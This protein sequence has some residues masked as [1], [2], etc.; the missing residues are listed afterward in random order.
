MSMNIGADIASYVKQIEQEASKV[1]R[2][3]NIMAALVRS[4]NDLSGTALRARS[5]Y[6]TASFNQISD[7][8]DLT[9]QTFTPSVQN[10][11]TPYEFGAQ[12]FITDT[13]LRNDPFNMAS[14]AR[15]ELGMAF[16]QKVEL[17]LLATFSSFTGGT[18]TSA[19]N[20]TWGMLLAA[21]SRLR[22]VA[23]RSDA[24]AVLSP[25]QWHSLGTAIAP[26]AGV[27]Q[28]N[29]PALQDALL[30]NYWVGN[31]G[32]LQIYVTSNLSAGTVT[33]GVFVPDAAALDVRVPFTIEPERDASRRGYELNATGTYAAGV[34][35]PRFGVQLISASTAPTA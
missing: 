5:E 30:R 7:S 18:V 19:G 25:Y 26:A 31:Y 24:V 15:D 29:A 16:A 14:E 33:A 1:A 35:R 3:N 9:S 12:F 32:G 21:Y 34:W 13:R 4:F 17:D 2:N 23:N 8:D 10:T 11:L 27:S 28:T 6:G 22:M 20:L